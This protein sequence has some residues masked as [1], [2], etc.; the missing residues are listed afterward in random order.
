M[1]EGSQ[2]ETNLQQPA[3]RFKR[4]EKELSREGQGIITGDLEYEEAVR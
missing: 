2:E 4:L 3:L 1:W